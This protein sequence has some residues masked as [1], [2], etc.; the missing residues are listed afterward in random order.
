[1]AGPTN[2]YAGWL[3]NRD[4]RQVLAETPQKLRSL[5]ERL[6]GEGLNRS[7]APGKWSARQ[8]LCHLADCEV[9][10]AFRYR[11]ALAEPHHTIQPFDQELWAAPY[12]SEALQAKL[13]V[14]VF[15][16]LRSWNLALL[17]TVSADSL[18][19]RVRHPERGELTFRNLIET[20]AG[21]DLNHL[22]QLEKIALDRAA[23]SERAPFGAFEKPGAGFD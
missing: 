9:A 8:I 17:N 23:S 11:Q 12:Q 2:P 3:G 7:Y 18:A 4:A 14:D 21:H 10:F 22:S 19:K 5:L 13:A 16:N 15:S 20:A 6:G 1:M